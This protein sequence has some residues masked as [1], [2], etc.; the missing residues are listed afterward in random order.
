MAPGGRKQK[1]EALVVATAKKLVNGGKG[2]EEATIVTEH[3]LRLWAQCCGPEPG[4]APGGPTA[5]SKGEPGQTLEGQ[6]QGDAA[7]VQ[8][9]ELGLRRGPTRKLKFPEAQEVVEEL[10]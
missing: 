10:K 5:S 2:V 7:A 8:S 9:S 3:Y 4:A 6:L 1:A